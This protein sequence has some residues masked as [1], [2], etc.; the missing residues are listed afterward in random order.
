MKCFLLNICTRRLNDPRRK[1]GGAGIPSAADA[2]LGL[3]PIA[4]IRLTQKVEAAAW[5]I[6][7]NAAELDRFRQAFFQRLQENED[8]NLADDITKLNMMDD[9]ASETDSDYTSYWRDWVS[10]SFFP[11]AP[12]EIDSYRCFR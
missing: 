11:D 4:A 5:E 3:N 8:Q 6:H 1:F 12:P 10:P 2:E 7:M 9:F